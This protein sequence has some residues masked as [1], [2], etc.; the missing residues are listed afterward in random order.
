MGTS[1]VAV[2][3]DLKFLP[4]EQALPYA[5]EK[6]RKIAT[7]PMAQMYNARE[8]PPGRLPTSAVHAGVH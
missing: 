4:F 1:N 7:R 2:K 8:L 6:V 3:K 5:R